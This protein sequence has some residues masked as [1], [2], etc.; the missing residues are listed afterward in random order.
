MY[1][2]MMM[3][4]FNTI[5]MIKNTALLALMALLIGACTDPKEKEFEALK[6]TYDE[7]RQSLTY[8]RNSFDQTKA[9]YMALREKYDSQP[10]KLGS[11]SLH[12][13]LRSNHNRLL[14][15]HEGFFEHQAE[16]L[17]KHDNLLKR[18]KVEGYPVDNRIADF[19]E[20]TTDLKKLIEE[21][22]FMNKEHNVMIEEQRG[23]LRTIDKPNLPT[24]PVERQQ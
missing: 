3:K 23:M 17:E 6:Q 20:M 13:Q 4:T 11:D 19:K 7:T 14:E 18:L 9:E 24:R 8:Y 21:Y 10:N 15:K 5:H 16:V 22:E 12:I 2:I 1:S